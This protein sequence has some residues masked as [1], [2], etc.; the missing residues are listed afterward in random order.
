LKKNFPLNLK[1]RRRRRWLLYCPFWK[2]FVILFFRRSG[3][4][5]NNADLS[6]VDNYWKLFN[7]MFKVVDWNAILLNCDLMLCLLMFFWSVAA[8][9]FKTFLIDFFTI[10]FERN[11]S[12]KMKIV[13]ADLIWSDMRLEYFFLLEQHYCIISTKKKNYR[14]TKKV[15]TRFKENKW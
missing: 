5:A 4:L 14:N 3:I 13:S 11:S 15:K 1:A 9:N 10:N 6:K 8:L 7:R 12:M 2:L